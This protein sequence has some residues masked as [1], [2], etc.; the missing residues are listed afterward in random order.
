LGKE[1]LRRAGVEETCCP[2]VLSSEL[3]QGIEALR[4]NGEDILKR[5]KGM[6][7]YLDVDGSYQAKAMNIDGLKKRMQEVAVAQSE[8]RS[9]SGQVGA[10][11]KARGI[12]KIVKDMSAAGKFAPGDVLVTGMTRPEFVP[13]MKM[14][15]AIITNEG[16]VT[17]HAAIVARELK[18]PCIIGTKMAT[19]VLKDGDLV[20]VDADNGVVNIL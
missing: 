12:V 3:E 6:M 2:Y 20:E 18:K 10:S 5:P 13:L 9:L 19:R 1:L 4:G 15:A 16:G 8:A 7:A 11:G 17:C 14:A